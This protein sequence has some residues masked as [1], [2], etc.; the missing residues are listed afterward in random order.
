MFVIAIDTWNGKIVRQTKDAPR[1]GRLM[2]WN[3]WFSYFFSIYYWPVMTKHT[4][5]ITVA[6]C[7]WELAVWVGPP[8][9]GLIKSTATA[10]IMDENIT[11]SHMCVMR[12]AEIIVPHN[13]RVIIYL[14]CNFRLLYNSGLLSMRAYP[15]YTNDVFMLVWLPLFRVCL[16]ARR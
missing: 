9:K 8:P 10:N 1:A 13:P 15:P 6:I 14:Y 5:H 11:R 7:A 4:A 2:A 16:R 3:I 12:L